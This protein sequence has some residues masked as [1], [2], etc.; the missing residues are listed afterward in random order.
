MLK[1]NILPV[2]AQEFVR[3]KNS[4]LNAS[5]VSLNLLINFL[6]KL[7]NINKNYFT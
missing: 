3:A 1:K 2:D 7:F 5:D 4:A 6:F